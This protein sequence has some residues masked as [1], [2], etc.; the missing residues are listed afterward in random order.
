[1]FVFFTFSNS[2][3]SL[4]LAPFPQPLFTAESA[5]EVKKLQNVGFPIPSHMLFKHFNFDSCSNNS[6]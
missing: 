1:M 4:S 5:G 3:T 2:V 6:L